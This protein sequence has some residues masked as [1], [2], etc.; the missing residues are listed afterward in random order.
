MERASAL[1]QEILAV[2]CK[3]LKASG[4][5]LCK[6]AMIN[7]SHLGGV[8]KTVSLR[9][10]TRCLAHVGFSCVLHFLWLCQWVGAEGCFSSVF[11]SLS[12]PFSS[13]LLC[14][15]GPCSL[16]RTVCRAGGV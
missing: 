4:F 12:G 10:R 3:T 9:P 6:V 7:H 16:L 14:Q 1:F 2:N 11:L 5:P 8:S 15:Y 13:G